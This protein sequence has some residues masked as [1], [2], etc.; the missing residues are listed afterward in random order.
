MIAESQAIFR[1]VSGASSSPVSVAPAPVRSSQVLVGH[2]DDDGRLGRWPARTH[3]RPRRAGR[4]R[5]EYPPGAGRWCAGPTRARSEG[6]GAASG[7]RIASS[8]A[9]PSGS[10]RSRYSAI[11]SSAYGWDS[12]R[13][14]SYWFSRRWNSANRPYFAIDPRAQRPDSPR[15]VGLRDRHEPAQ[16]RLRTAGVSRC[17]SLSIS[18]NATAALRTGTRALQHRLAQHAVAGAWQLPRPPAPAQPHHRPGRTVPTAAP[19]LPRTPHPRPGHHHE[20]APGPA[21]RPE[22]PPSASSA[23]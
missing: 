16:H 1:T 23:R 22:P 17:N 7:P 21:H 15:P 3:P 11:P 13:P 14:R 5:P 4:P 19:T 18:P 10:S 8:T 6:C 20:T 9:R 12:D 2:R